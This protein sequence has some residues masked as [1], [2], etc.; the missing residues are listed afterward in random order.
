M[1]RPE[2][3][4]L[5]HVDEDDDNAGDGVHVVVVAPLGRVHLTGVVV[6]LVHWVCCP[7]STENVIGIAA[8]ICN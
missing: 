7:L 4:V 1:E 5:C 3:R 2:L 6:L 8:F